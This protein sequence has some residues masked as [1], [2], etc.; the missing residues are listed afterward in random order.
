MKFNSFALTLATAGSFVAAQH[1]PHRHHHKRDTPTVV[2][3][4]L[5][6]NAISASEVCQGLHDGSLEYKPG[7][8]TPVVDPCQEG[9]ASSNSNPSSTLSVEPAEF[10]ETSASATPAST[11]T[12]STSAPSSGSSSGSSGGKGLGRDFPDGE[13]DCSSFPSDY[14]AVPL[15]YLKLGGWTGIQ[16]PTYSGSF[17]NHIRT[18]VA[19]NSCDEEGALCSYACPPGYQKAQWPLTQG[20]TGQSVGGLQCKGGKLYLTNKELSSKLCIEGVGGVY[21]QNKLGEEVAICRTDYPG[22]EA[23]TIPLSLGNN[24]LQPLTCPDG[25]KYFK[26]QG[27]ITSAQYYVN[28]K[29]VSTEKACQW[30]NGKEPIG[31]WAPINLGVGE[32]NGKWLSI[33]QNAPT[34]TEK[35]DFNIKIQGDDLS[36]SCKYEN[37]QF[38]SDTGSNG[39]GCTV[40]VMS[41]DAT[42]VFY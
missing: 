10:A 34:T 26:W 5:D 18:A 14:G 31:N 38:S 6:G 19:G 15:D 39:S 29:G 7:E 32:N 17:V 8:P 9:S 37:G 23:E 13:I 4:V 21:A 33:F 3:Y 42:F 27:K 40:Q 28:P 2:K 35:L 24:E 22:T 12:A 16:Y 20:S 1:Q 41:G 25:Q 30:G 36:G 11:S